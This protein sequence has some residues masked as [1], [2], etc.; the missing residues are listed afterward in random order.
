MRGLVVAAGLAALVLLMVWVAWADA[1]AW[2]ALIEAKG[3]KVFEEVPEQYIPA[4]GFDSSGNVTHTL[5]RVPGRTSYQCADGI[6][7]HRNT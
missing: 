1:E 7:R 6:T 2:E 5:I 3:C 4:T